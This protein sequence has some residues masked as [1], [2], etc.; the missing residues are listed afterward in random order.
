M[1]WKYYGQERPPF[2]EIPK[3]GQESVWDYPRPPRLEIDHREVLVKYHSTL[4]ARTHR[5]IRILET[6][7]PPTYY[8]PPSDVIW[9]ELEPHPG[10]SF[11]EWKGSAS[12]WSLRSSDVKEPTAWSYCHPSDAFAD[13]ANYVC[14]YAGKVACYIDGER[15]KPQSGRFYGGWITNA[16]TGP[17]KGEPGT[18]SW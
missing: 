14:F 12:Y 1:S 10:L 5:A 9:E 16:L 6:A 17:F 3:K 13:I 8:I 11:C 2:A 18:E 7:S 15:V 4:I